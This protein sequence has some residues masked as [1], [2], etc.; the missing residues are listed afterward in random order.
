MPY[1]KQ[2]S[3]NQKNVMINF[4]DFKRRIE[5]L[6]NFP[7]LTGRVSYA[8]ISL[9]GDRI[10]LLRVNRDTY[11]TFSLEGL[12]NAYRA[13]DNINTINIQQFITNRTYSPACA[14]LIA[15]GLY[16]KQGVRL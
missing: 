12:Y 16:N 13:L 1:N 15:I 8:D 9:N 4:N 10:K 7:S 5:N 14:M 6:R 11:C 3:Y 2:T